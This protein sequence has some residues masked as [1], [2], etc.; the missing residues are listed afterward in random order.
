MNRSQMYCICSGNDAKRWVP[1]TGYCSP[2][3]RPPA[4]QAWKT[5][6]GGQRC[7]NF[8]E[9]VKC[10]ERKL[11]RYDISAYFDYH[12]SDCFHSVMH[13]FP[14]SWVGVQI[15]QPSDA[16][17]RREGI[18]CLSMDETGISL[19]IHILSARNSKN[20]TRLISVSQNLCNLIS[21]RERHRQNENFLYCHVHVLTSHCRRPG[22]ASKELALREKL[23]PGSSVFNG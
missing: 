22:A 21:A 18:N 8:G 19:H 1:K 9:G 10:A 17:P 16:L 3:S 6:C 11:I 12:I 2:W 20:P 7:E 13:D 14:Q 23:L 15:S 5:L 4:L